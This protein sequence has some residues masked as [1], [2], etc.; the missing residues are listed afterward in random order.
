MHHDGYDYTDGIRRWRSF[1]TT[2]FEPGTGDLPAGF[3]VSSQLRVDEE[4]KAALAAAYEAPFPDASFKAGIRRFPW[5]LPFAQPGEGNAVDQER[6]FRALAAWTKPIH[7]IFGDRD[8]VFT[9][10]WERSWAAQFAQA[11]VDMVSGPHFPQE[12]S[13]EAIVGLMLRY[14]SL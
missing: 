7:F 11:T 1:A 3:I 6:C 13:P 14:M 5:M 2:R 10:E 8:D 12:E 4:R 9:L